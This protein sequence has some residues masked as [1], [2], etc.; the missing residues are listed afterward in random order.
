MA[1]PKIPTQ[2]AR[3]KPGWPSASDTLGRFGARALR[4]SVD[5]ASAFRVPAWIWA[6]AEARSTNIKV[7]RPPMMSVM[8]CGVLL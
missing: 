7:A 6:V 4:F 2:A 5:T 3:S 1:G 8:A